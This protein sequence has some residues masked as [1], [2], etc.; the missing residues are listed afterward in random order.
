MRAN[1]RRL[2][3][4]ILRAL[5]VLAVLFFHFSVPGVGGG[6]IGVDIFFVISGYLISAHI[7]KDISAGQ[8]RFFA[9]Y[10]RR[11]RRLVPALTA[12][13][14]FVWVGALVL[15][16]IDAFD[17]TLTQGVS[18][19]AY[20]SNVLFWW[21]SGYFDTEALSKP[22][23]HTWSLSVEEQFYL[24]WPLLLL[25]C[26]RKK[27][28]VVLAFVALL[29]FLLCEWMMNRDSAAAFFLFPFRIYEFAIGAS[30]LFF[31]PPKATPWITLGSGLSLAVIVMSATIIHEN[32]RFPGA[33]VLPVCLATA[34]LIWS[35]PK[36]LNA[37]HIANRTL[38]WLGKISYS[39]YLVHWPLVVWKDGA[40]DQGSVFVH[41]TT[42]MTVSL[43]LGWL[44]WRWVE[45]PMLNSQIKIHRFIWAIPL[46]IMI[47]TGLWAWGSKPY[48]WIHADTRSVDQAIAALQPRR[49]FLPRLIEAEK[50]KVR[51][52]P[53]IAVVGDSHAVDMFVALQLT[54]EDRAQPK[55]VRELCD[56]VLL[57]N[58]EEFLER[59]YQ[60]HG[61]PDVNA[62]I[63]ARA[64]QDLLQRILDTRPE[65]VVISERWR[66]KAIPFLE[67]T[68]STLQQHTAANI[69]ILSRNQEFA[70]PP[71]RVVSG[72]KTMEQINDRAWER[73]VDHASINQELQQIADIT[74]VRFVNRSTMICRA[75]ET[76][77]FYQL[78]GSFLYIDNSHWTEAGMRFFGEKL[79]HYILHD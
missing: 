14:I 64:N 42:L 62:A 1:G 66:E 19:A 4:D 30:V 13:I 16:P 76:S 27:L 38:G 15:Q 79:L 67:E 55:L 33:S 35:R 56:P 34:W 6:F 18:A 36:I 48:D 69:V 47:A 73:R 31:R 77:C 52:G 32:S 68:I 7:L 70:G 3:I 44:M 22:L 8:F 63:C 17:E 9:F 25:L 24:F 23:L 40:M 58:D 75:E 74:G 57:P 50:D 10:A 46:S 71:G 26:A 78:N 20:I 21:Q 29:P 59:H 12:T 51:A 49:A 72:L 65:V 43:V 54:V 39:L 2:D 41:A 28:P 11:A 37:Q 45:Q 5:A 60:D 61:N 53:V